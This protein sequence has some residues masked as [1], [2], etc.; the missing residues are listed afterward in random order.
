MKNSQGG[1]IKVDTSAAALSER[2]GQIQQVIDELDGAARQYGGYDNIPTNSAAMQA[3]QVLGNGN[4][5]T[6]QALAEQTDRAAGFVTQRSSVSVPETAASSLM[7]ADVADSEPMRVVIH[8][9]RDIAWE[10]GRAVPVSGGVAAGVFQNIGDSVIGVASLTRDALLTQQ[11]I[12]AGGDNEFNRS[13]WGFEYRQ[14]AFQNSLAMGDAIRT[15]ASDPVGYL[16]E[17]VDRTFEGIKS[18]LNTVRESTDLGDWFLYGASVGHATMGLATAVAGIAGTVR[19]VTSGIGKLGTALNARIVAY[20]VRESAFVPELSIGTPN[21]P[22]KIESFPDSWNKFDPGLNQA[23][24]SELNKFG[25]MD[26]N[27]NPAL[28]GGEGQLFLSDANPD[29]ALK[30]WYQTRV[31]DLDQSVAVL[32]DAGAVVRRDM[33][34]NTTLDVVNIYDRGPDWVLRDFYPDSLP[35]RSALGDMEVAD[36]L[37]RTRNALQAND[38]PSLSDL[39]MRLGV[40][41]PQVS[42][43]MEKA[44]KLPMVPLKD[45]RLPTRC[46]ELIDQKKCSDQRRPH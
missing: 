21:I 8:G 3:A 1:G 36:A 35:L 6:I 33:T 18:R 24:H 7:T 16:G 45:R 37:Q 19:S 4:S 31:G 46:C 29:L 9:S 20:D 5:L 41:W 38:H 40:V 34:L 10:A 25:T 23:F 28:R 44:M 27:P 30:R 32:H 15:I 14:Q 26:L 13:V 39:A 12:I 43:W 42:L 17:S 2:N 22:A 11:Y